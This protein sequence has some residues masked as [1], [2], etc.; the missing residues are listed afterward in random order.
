MRN[1]TQSRPEEV[2][3]WK[4]ELAAVKRMDREQ[5]TS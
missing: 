5:T 4:W 2:N 3:N 1:N